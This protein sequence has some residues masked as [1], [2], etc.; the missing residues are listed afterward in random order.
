MSSA[1]VMSC[2]NCSVVSPAVADYAECLYSEQMQSAVKSEMKTMIQ[3]ARLE[4]SQI[5]P[6]HAPIPDLD[7]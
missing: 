7:A 1:L 3:R 2:R 5:Q 6:H 4:Y